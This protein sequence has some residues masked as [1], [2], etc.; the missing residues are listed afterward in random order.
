MSSANFFV[1]NEGHMKDAKYM[2]WNIASSPKSDISAIYAQ[3]AVHL[4]IY[5]PSK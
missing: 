4:R 1:L 3:A 2:A 5:V